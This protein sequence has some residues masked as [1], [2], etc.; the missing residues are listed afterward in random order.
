VVKNHSG[1][2]VSCNPGFG[3]GGSAE[4][5]LS[6]TIHTQS[7]RF[8]SES[9]LFIR[10]THSRTGAR[11]LASIRHDVVLYS[12]KKIF[13]TKGADFRHFPANAEI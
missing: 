3:L 5:S 10:A 13:P 12:R 1:W 11:G 9:T 8:T 6:N 7:T 4:D 2:G